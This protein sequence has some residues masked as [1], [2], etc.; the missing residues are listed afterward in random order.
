LESYRS[1]GD[2]YLRILDEA[3]ALLPTDDLRL[4]TLGIRGDTA[5]R[6][7]R[8]DDAV[9]IQ[10]ECLRIVTSMPGIV[11]ADSVCYYVW[12]LIASGDDDAARTALAE[13]RLLPGLERWHARP[14]LLEA[15][16]ALL[17][18]NV[19]ALD[20]IIASAQVLQPFDRA[21]MWQVS[22]VVIGGPNGHR[23]LRA[24]YDT[25][26]QAG[27]HRAAERSR[28]LLRDAGAPVPRA[29]RATTAVPP[30]LARLGV[31]GR[32]AEVLRLVGDGLSNSEIADQLVVSVRTVESHVSA[33]LTKL[34]VDRR[35]R[36]AALAR[37]VP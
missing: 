26:A 31:T 5:L 36:L 13:V 33:L 29:R 7:G 10:R 12:S 9:Q 2:G 17:A 16:E 3:D 28:Q 1:E 25:F 32:E 20:R 8:W 23:W 18:R 21:I 15:A 34:G 22:G 19:A 6:D 27:A 30:E 37:S 14:I 24:A 11:P 4:H 35:G